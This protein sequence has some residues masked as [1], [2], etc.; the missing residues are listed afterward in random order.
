MGDPRKI[1]KKFSTPSHPWRAERIE[2]EHKLA[3][4]FG[5]KNMREIWKGK[6]FLSTASYQAKRLISLHTPQA[7]IEKKQLLSRLISLG[8]LPVTAT[9]TD[10]LSLTVKDVLSRRLQTLVVQKKFARTMKQARQFIT[11]EHFMVNNKVVSSPSY[12]TSKMEE[13]LITFNPTSNLSST[14][15]PERAIKEGGSK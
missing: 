3:K 15:H 11:H 8:M 9:L 13:D 5:L 1:R 14:E 12:L 2:E 10:V 7:E 4:D 6:T